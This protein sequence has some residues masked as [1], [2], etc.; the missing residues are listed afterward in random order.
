L[1]KAEFEADPAFRQLVAAGVAERT[2][3][4]GVR[5]NQEGNDRLREYAL[6]GRLTA[7]KP[8]VAQFAGDALE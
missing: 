4:G 8:D 7:G 2:P 6:R 5:I 1:T 3:D